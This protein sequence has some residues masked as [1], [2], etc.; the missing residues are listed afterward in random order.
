M[1][2]HP[3]DKQAKKPEG[4]G[5]NDSS[6]Y[7]PS[8][9]PDTRQHAEERETVIDERLLPGGA[10]GAAVDVGMSGIDR[11]AIPTGADSP[12]QTDFGTADETSKPESR[13]R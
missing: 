4:V 5:T 10:H 1:E 13:G 3:N 9:A 7:A 12:R 6:E 11:A 8:K 2:N